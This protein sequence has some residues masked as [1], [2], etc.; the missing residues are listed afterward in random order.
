MSTSV[1]D[2]RFKPFE[3]KK[4]WQVSKVWELHDEIK[5]RILLGQKNTIIAEAL[6]CTPQTV[7]NVRN[8]AVIQDQLAIMRGARDAY[9]LDIARDIR[10]F[11][12]KALEVLKEVVMG[13]GAGENASVALRARYAADIL[14][15]AGHSATRNIDFRGQHLHLTK[16][17][18]EEI[19]RRAFNSPVIDVKAANER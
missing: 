10:D 5:R 12:P 6:G 2:K 4:T 16:D 1:L 3:V 9:T 13:R 15:R 18:L 17:D 11:A 8:S 14:D 19:K 7:S